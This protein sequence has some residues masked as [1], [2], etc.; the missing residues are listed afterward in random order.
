MKI[1][2][3]NEN[4]IKFTLSSEDLASRH[5]RVSELVYSS[6]KAKNLFN[7]LMQRA[8]K[9][10]GFEHDDLPLMIEA[11]PMPQDG[12]ILVV[13]KMDD[14]EELDAR[15]SN[16]SPA[17]A[18]APAP[19]PTADEI[20]NTF[21]HLDSVLKDLG[22]NKLSDLAGVTV[23]ED[24]DEPSLK[25]IASYSDALARIYVFDNFVNLTKLAAS[26]V[27]FYKGRN[28]LFRDPKSGYYYLVMYISD[29]TPEEFNRVCNIVSEYGDPAKTTYATF[30]YF[31][32][33]F[34]TII[35]DKAL[36]QLAK[37]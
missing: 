18:S 19:L 32:E 16:F 25:E 10:V 5:L 37:L 28:T 13:T 33:H 36:A 15:F 22:I 34:K 29:H 30:A 21:E 14:P 11:I 3:I 6:D 31:E 35:K 27:P 1:E 7:E 26:L 8:N 9:E 2:R 23:P 24:K 4:Q 17:K 20:I 12:L